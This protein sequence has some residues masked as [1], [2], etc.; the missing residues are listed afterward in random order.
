M[1]LIYCVWV[2]VRGGGSGK[3]AE[4][5]NDGDGSGEEEA[6]KEEIDTQSHGSKNI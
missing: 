1:V 3:D 5:G 2:L 4:G 6:V